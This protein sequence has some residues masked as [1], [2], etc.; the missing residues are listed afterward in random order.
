MTEREKLMRFTDELVEDILETPAEEILREF[1]EMPGGAEPH[2]VKMRELIRDAVEEANKANLKEVKLNAADW[3]Y[4]CGQLI[5]LEDYTE[6][7]SERNYNLIEQI[8][9]QLGNRS[10]KPKD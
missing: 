5:P 1:E 9:Y 3:E 10:N 4:I 6:T 8:Q 2:I 7:E